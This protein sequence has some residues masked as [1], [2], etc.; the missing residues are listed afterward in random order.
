MPLMLI[1]SQKPRMGNKNGIKNGFPKRCA[2]LSPEKSKEIVNRICVVN[3]NI[4]IVLAAGGTRRTTNS[5]RRVYTYIYY[6]ISA[7]LAH[8]T[9]VHSAMTGNCNCNCI[10][11]E[12]AVAIEASPKA[13]GSIGY[14]FN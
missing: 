12:L 13:F 8:N 14:D 7:Y 2:L 11:A 1:P 5:F 4:K 3:A 6:C 10:I 9:T